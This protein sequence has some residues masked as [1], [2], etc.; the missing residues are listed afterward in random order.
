MPSRK[1]GGGV[2]KRQVGRPRCDR[3]D[4]ADA[5]RLKILDA[6]TTLL[7]EAGSAQLSITKVATRAE[8]TPAAVH[9]HFK[10][11]EALIDAV[12]QFKI[13]PLIDSI[14]GALDSESSDPIEIALKVTRRIFTIGCDHPWLPPVWLTEIAGGKGLLRRRL[15]AHLPRQ[16]L[17]R[18]MSLMEH[19]QLDGTINPLIAPQLA[20]ANILGITML[21]LAPKPLWP[22]FDRPKTKAT[23]EA[24]LRHIEA[25]LRYGLAATT[26]QKIR[27]RT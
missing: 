8:Y 12:F 2:W 24:V 23:K 6:A 5:S 9:Y 13:L 7:A 1:H 21:T 17:Q 4:R 26:K 14:W 10:N 25:M 11:R 3:P 27:S 22:I 16:K 18:F 15:F 19:G 20:F